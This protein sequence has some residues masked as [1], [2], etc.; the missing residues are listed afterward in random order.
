MML[1]CR[2]RYTPYNIE[3]FEIL[4]NITAESA[5]LGFAVESNLSSWIVAIHHELTQ[6]ILGQLAD[7]FR[8]ITS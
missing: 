4:L 8:D 2:D 5:T 6:H 3:S 7:G 1:L